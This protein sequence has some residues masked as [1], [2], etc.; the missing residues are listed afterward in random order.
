M[1][2]GSYES[3]KVEE[4]T[5][6]DAIAVKNSTDLFDIYKV[7]YLIQAA[8]EDDICRV[9]ANWIDDHIKRRM[10]VLDLTSI[11]MDIKKNDED[12]NNPSS[13]LLTRTHLCADIDM[14]INLTENKVGR[15]LNY[16][17]FFKIPW[18][19]DKIHIRKPSKKYTSQ[20]SKEQKFK[21]IW[22]SN[23]ITAIRNW[24]M[25][26]RYYINKNGIYIHSKDAWQQKTGKKDKDGNDIIETKDFEAMLSF[27]FLSNIITF[28][29]DSDRRLSLTTLYMDTIEREKWFNANK[30]NIKINICQWTKKWDFYTSQTGSIYRNQSSD[31]KNIMVNLSLKQQEF[32]S[33]YFKI[34]KFNRRNL[35][36]VNSFF[37]HDF[38][39]HMN[40]NEML[41]RNWK[42]VSIL[43]ARDYFLKSLDGTIEG[44]VFKLLTMWDDTNKWEILWSDEDLEREIKKRV[45]N[46]P[47]LN[48]YDTHNNQRHLIKTMK[49]YKYDILGVEDIALSIGDYR[50][51]YLKA[52]YLSKFYVNN[53]KLELAQP[54]KRVWKKLRNQWYNYIIRK[55]KNRNSYRSPKVKKA[56]IDKI[57][58]D[59]Y[60]TYLFKQ[61]TRWD[62][63]DRIITRNNDDIE[64][65]INDNRDYL[66]FNTS[67]AKKLS[68]E[69]KEILEDN[70]RNVIKEWK[71]KLDTVTLIW[72]EE[73]IRNAF[74]HHHYTIIPWFNKILLWDPSIDDTPNWEEIYDLDELYQNAVSRV[75]EDYLDIKVAA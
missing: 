27:N 20:V 36:V 63:K 67:Y 33:E 15:I 30:N 52:L 62:I 46:D 13:R 45:K 39:W 56:W 41:V 57:F 11:W 21:D 1:A 43:Q 58:T 7:Q 73:H 34:H 61:F 12:P 59:Y 17:D 35:Q 9:F 2:N 18:I 5:I 14:F 48:L 74:A 37:T 71:E 32:L 24:L 64:D 40:A 55:C 75:D 54:Q 42:I 50:K 23:I 47:V 28:C 69:Q 72:E 6:D 29:M 68:P 25:H 10:D 16:D 26:N 31:L 8:T 53:P 51:N 66:M 3:P 44:Y 19:C 60:R 38:S 65:Y 70:V 49:A 4:Y 22:F